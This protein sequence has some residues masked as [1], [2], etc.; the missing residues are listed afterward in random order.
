MDIL[1]TD[2][3]GIVG[4]AIHL[5]AGLPEGW[6]RYLASQS[7]AAPVLPAFS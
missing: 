4:T 5:L 6:I 1:I 3:A 2:V 7:L